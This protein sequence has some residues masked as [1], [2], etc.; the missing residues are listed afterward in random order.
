MA[1]EQIEHLVVNRLDFQTDGAVKT[2]ATFE[3]SVTVDG[4][5]TADHIHTQ[6]VAGPIYVHIK[7]TE[8]T[9]LPAGTPVYATGFVDSTYGTT[10]YVEVKKALANNPAK[11]TAIGITKQSIAAGGNGD[12]VVIGEALGVDTSTFSLNQELWVAPTGGLVGTQPPSSNV[13][14]P[15][16]RVLRV[17]STQGIIF[18]LTGFENKQ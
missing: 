5:L 7:N 15:M 6:G 12:C 4:L 9:T 17:S 13:I 1:F 10:N 11:M 18:V 3:K 14:Q 8:T 16:G 2:D